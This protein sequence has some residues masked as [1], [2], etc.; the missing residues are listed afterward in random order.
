VAHI[1]QISDN[2]LASSFGPSENGIRVARG[3]A[4]GKS[5]TSAQGYMDRDQSW[6][7]SPSLYFQ[8][9]APKP[10]H[11]IFPLRRKIKVFLDGISVTV[12]GRGMLMGTYERR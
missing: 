1:E 10:S 3:M 2:A 5:T 11:R 9:L 7:W 4:L 8:I 12:I 6:T